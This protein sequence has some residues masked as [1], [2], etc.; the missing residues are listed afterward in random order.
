MYA[1]QQVVW[2]AWID[3]TLLE[4]WWIPA[5]LLTR[6]DQLEVRLGGAF[7]TSMSEDGKSVGPHVDGIFLVV[8]GVNRLVF[9]NVID[10]AV[11]AESRTAS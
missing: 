9:T 1:P 5:P 4:Q 10:N 6:V 11:L 2:P 7:V 3:P 8:E